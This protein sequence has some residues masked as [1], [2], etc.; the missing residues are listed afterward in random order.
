[1]A[2]RINPVKTI[3]TKTSP[4]QLWI[5]WHGALI[6]NFGKKTANM[7]F[8]QAWN[9]R[10]GVEARANT[11]TLRGYLSEYGLSIERGTMS[12]VADFGL[13]V[14]DSITGIFS[15]GSKILMVIGI[16]I[17]GTVAF[18][19]YRVVKKVTA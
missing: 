8:I 6:K 1:M 12:A 15:I 10:G 14:W 18:I 2:T 16:V 11:T 17:L 5:E 19:V 7:L 9:K 4:D 13:G 3:P